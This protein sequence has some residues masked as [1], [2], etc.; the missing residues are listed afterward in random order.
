MWKV[1]EFI[2]YD[3]SG[4]IYFNKTPNYLDNNAITNPYR[5]MFLNHTNIKKAS[6]NYV[7]RG[8]NIS[9]R[10]TYQIITLPNGIVKPVFNDNVKSKEMHRPSMV[11][12][13]F[14]ISGIDCDDFV[15]PTRKYMVVGELDDI[16]GISIN[17]YIV[18]QIDGDTSHSVFS[19]TKNDCKHLGINYESGLQLIPKSSNIEFDNYISGFDGVNLSTYP[20]SFED[21][22]SIMFMLI[23]LPCLNYGKQMII[24]NMLYNLDRIKIKTKTNIVGSNGF[25][26]L[27]TNQNV[28]YR[29]IEQSNSNK[30]LLELS[31]CTVVNNEIHGLDPNSINGCFDDFFSVEVKVKT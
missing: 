1:N 26:T 7:F 16:D 13:T 18:K 2:E 8:Y 20:L 10:G 4:N 22:K 25:A 19:L 24:N 28:H 17:S 6:P 3:S 31:F 29:I 12:K 14:S 11:N 30:I 27:N 23:E 15:M 5:E 9:E 21:K